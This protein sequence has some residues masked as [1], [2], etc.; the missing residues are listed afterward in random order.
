M[1]RGKTFEK[2]N[3]G[4]TK[5]ATT[6]MPSVATAKVTAATSARNQLSNLAEICS[7]C[8]ITSPQTLKAAKGETVAPTAQSAQNEPGSPVTPASLVLAMSTS[9]G[10]PCSKEKPPALT[11]RP[12]ASTSMA[13]QTAGPAQSWKRRTVSMPFWMISSCNAQTMTKQI[14]SSV[15]WPRKC[16]DFWNSMIASLR[17]SRATIAPDAAAVWA[18]YQ[19]QATTA[20]TS[21][22]RLAPQTPNEARAST[23]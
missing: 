22:G 23:G 1:V 7:G 13:I 11:T 6:L 15:E 10:M 14:T 17:V 18:P 5:L 21:A 20:R 9:C 3:A 12:I 19:K 2:S 8:S 16:D 4:E